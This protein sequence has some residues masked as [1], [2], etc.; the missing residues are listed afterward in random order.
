MP[1]GES[2]DQLQRVVAEGK[3]RIF[4]G[5]DYPIISPYSFVHQSLDLLEDKGLLSADKRNALDEIYHYNPLLFD[6]VLKRTVNIGG[7]A[8]PRTTF[9][10]AQ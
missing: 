4:N 7:R 5:S 10:E 8:L 3:G 1:Y 6:F 9:L 2:A